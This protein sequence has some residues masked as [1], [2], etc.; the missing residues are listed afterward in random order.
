MTDERHVLIVE[1]DEQW[2]AILKETLQDEGYDVTVIA[3]Y[4]Y[5]RQALRE[6]GFDLVILD[7]ELDAA[8]PTLEGKRLLNLISRH[9]PGTPCIV[10]SGKGD[11]QIVRDAFKRYHV[12]D[13]ITKELFDIPTF[14]R[15]VQTALRPNV[16]SA[17]LRRILSE[18]E[19]LDA[20]DAGEGDVQT[21]PQY[22]H[23]LQ[24]I[25]SMGKVMERSPRAFVE[26]GEEDLRQH[27]L[28]QL[29]GQYAGR[30]TGETFNYTGK[31][32]ILVRV[33]DKNIFIE[34]LQ[35]ADGHH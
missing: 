12:V 16:A 5:S 8:A 1:D 28:V 19:V 3:N 9:Y 26:M 23:I 10:V 29:N 7:L 18:Q 21:I 22:E 20:L 11:T 14:I 35:G 2:Q 30:A 17:T 31:T 25:Q 27:F 33:K 6:S 32:D 15:A 4:Q 24:I 34:G 13:Y